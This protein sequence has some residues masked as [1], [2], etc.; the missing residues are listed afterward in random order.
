VG[1][2]QRKATKVRKAEVVDRR[3]Y[4]LLVCTRVPIRVLA[5]MREG[6]RK[7]GQKLDLEFI[8][9]PWARFLFQADS[10]RG[11]SSF[12]LTALGLPIRIYLCHDQEW[13]TTIWWSKKSASFH[14]ID[15]S[16]G[17]D[18]LNRVTGMP[19]AFIVKW[20]EQLFLLPTL[21]DHLLKKENPTKKRNYDSHLN[22]T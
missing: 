15:S 21:S 14:P 9:F 2:K 1:R 17:L 6:R 16:K 5:A 8:F 20:F 10:G 18:P 22:F 4:H 13:S 11:A 3:G 7:G 19:E 12:N